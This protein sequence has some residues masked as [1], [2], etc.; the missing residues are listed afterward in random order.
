MSSTTARF[1]SV[2]EHLILS[3]PAPHIIM[4]KMNRPKQLNAMSYEM[5]R[6]M[7]K[8]LDW[9]EEEPS[10]WVVILTGNGRA[11]CAGQDL[12]SFM[13]AAN[14]ESTSDDNFG[15]DVSSHARR[16]E[17]GGFGSVSTRRL[18]KPII[19]AVD[20][21]AMGGGTELVLNCDLV[22]AT[23]RSIF[24]LP[25][26]SRGVVAAMG[27]ITRISEVAGHQRASEMLLVGAPL[28]AQDAYARFN[29][30]NALINVEKSASIEAGQAAVEAEAL[31][32][33][34]K[35]VA[36]SPDA[37]LVTKEA[38]NMARDAGKGENGIDKVSIESLSGE[39]SQ[40]LYGGE[41]IREGLSAFFEVRI[42]LC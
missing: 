25:E 4:M 21:P 18:S 38:L 10:V 28:S 35:V 24:A 37:V 7:K 8:V 16:I 29:F 19:A 9:V 12:K 33:A 30:V 15:S 14:N 40:A 17:D 41:N 6:D 27:G 36:N 3:T 5:E 23:S 32:W 39:R 1:P 2:G 26:V 34:H 20:G 11:F 22:V 42:C 31:R 13:D